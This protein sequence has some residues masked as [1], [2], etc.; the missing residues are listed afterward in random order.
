MTYDVAI[1]GAKP[2]DGSIVETVILGGLTTNGQGIGNS[3]IVAP[4]VSEPVWVRV[5]LVVPPYDFETPE[6]N[7]VAYAT[8]KI[9]NVP[10]P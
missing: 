10:V 3:H 5:R 4:L 1:G 2:H 7:I 9:T 8:K 6:N